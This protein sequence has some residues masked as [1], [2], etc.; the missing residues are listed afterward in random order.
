MKKVILFCISMLL[1][2]S[3]SAFENGGK[4]KFEKDRFV[5]LEHSQ[6]QSPVL[7]SQV[8]FTQV[9]IGKLKIPDE[10]KT[11]GIFLFYNFI[12]IDF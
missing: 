8:I 6:V 11:S 12:I 3:A 1:F 4:L 9:E 10:M 2:V 7:E 5:L